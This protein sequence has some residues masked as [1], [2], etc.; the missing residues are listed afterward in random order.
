MYNLLC[1]IPSSH[2]YASQAARA[3]SLARSPLHRLS[4]HFVVEGHNQFIFV[5]SWS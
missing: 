2:S 1:A 4:L 3:H 5:M